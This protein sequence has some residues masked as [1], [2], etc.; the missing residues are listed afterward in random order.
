MN[1]EKIREIALEYSKLNPEKTYNIKSNLNWFRYVKK[2][3]RVSKFLPKKGKC[4][5]LGCGIG[6][7]SAMI[8]VIKPNLEVISVDIKKFPTWRSYKNFGC[9]FMV[10]D[11]E[12]LKF[13][14]NY[15]DVVISFGVM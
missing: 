4:L 9:N 7:V 14:S 11:A 2:L 8:K 13:K 1:F 3:K 12:K 5:E 6:H 10:D 15:F